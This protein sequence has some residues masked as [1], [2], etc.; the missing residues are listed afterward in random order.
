MR[1]EDAEASTWTHDIRASRE[2]FMAPAEWVGLADK[3]EVDTLDDPLSL[4]K[5]ETESSHTI[6]VGPN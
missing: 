1:T 6:T 4:F 3:P 2:Y 5:A